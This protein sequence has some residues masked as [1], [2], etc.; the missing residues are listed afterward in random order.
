MILR[1][2]KGMEKTKFK[3]YDIHDMKVRN[4]YVRYEK[5]IDGEVYPF[6]YIRKGNK[7]KCA[8]DELFVY[9][10]DKCPKFTKTNIVRMLRSMIKSKNNYISSLKK[11]H[12][13]SDALLYRAFGNVDTLESVL[14]Y[15]LKAKDGE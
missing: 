11:D 3:Y 12:N 1:M 7:Y 13:P 10:P 14:E 6:Y 15:V 5:S 2:E 9:D 4:V 8:V